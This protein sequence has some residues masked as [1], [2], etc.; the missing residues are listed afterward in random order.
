MKT[1]KFTAETIIEA[2]DEDEAKSIFAN[3]SDNFAYEADCE[4]IKN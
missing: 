3:N 2:E 1:F 4:E